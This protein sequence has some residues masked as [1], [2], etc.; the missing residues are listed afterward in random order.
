MLPEMPPFITT[1]LQN[2]LVQKSVTTGIVFSIIVVVSGL[3][4]STLRRRIANGAIRYRVRKGVNLLGFV[5]F[6]FSLTLIFND[7]LSGLRLAFGVAGA[8]I[9]FAL[10]EV[11]TSIAGWVA[12]SFTTIFKPGDRIQIGELRGDVIDIGVLRTTLMEIGGWVSGDLYSGRM[13]RISN[14]KIFSESVFN[15][16]HDFPFVWDEIE[17]PVR[18]GSDLAKAHQLFLNVLEGEVGEFADEAEEAW[19]MVNRRYLIEKAS[20]QPIV[21]VKAD[22]NWATFTLRYITDYQKRGSNKTALYTRILQE[23]D[24]SQGQVMMAAAELDITKFPQ[25]DINLHPPMNLA[26]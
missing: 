6:V 8:G 26:N 9:A 21:F 7:A 1:L 23:M 18:Y 3:I 13:V 20:V 10:Q 15:Y 19:H 22:Q 2:P 14:S 25:V 4:K 11:I 5:L 24:A 17:I 16:N 12:I